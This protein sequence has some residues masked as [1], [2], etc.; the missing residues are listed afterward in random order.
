MY[1][2]SEEEDWS[3]PPNDP[4]DADAPLKPWQRVLSI[5]VITLISLIVALFAVL[6]VAAEPMP[7]P[8]VNER[9]TTLPHR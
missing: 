9:T 8:K 7:T 5:A 2:N 3:P 6:Y 4:D 1:L